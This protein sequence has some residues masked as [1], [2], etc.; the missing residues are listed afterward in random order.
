MLAML[1]VSAWMIASWPAIANAA[2]RII[3]PDAWGESASAAPEAQR[4]ASRWQAAL[5]LRLVQVVSA[6]QD[7]R[8]AE[9]VAV[10]ER[11]EPVPEQAFAT[12]TAAIEALATAVVNVV[13]TDAPADAELR[14]TRSGEQIVWAR[15]TVDD[16]RYE[17]VLAPSGDSATI[18]IAAVLASEAERARPLLD[19]LFVGLDGVSAPMPR[20]SL[21]AWQLGSIV[22]W[23]ALALGL[24]AAMLPLGDR[25][26]DHGQAGA[27]ASGI[28]LVLVLIGTGIAA[29]A[30]R[31]RELALVHAGSSV[32]GL[33]VWVGVA[34]VIVVGLHFLISS[35]LD[36]GPVQSAPSSGAFASGTYSTADVIRSS[37]SRSGMR[38]VP[39]DLEQS[40]SSGAWPTSSPSES[41]ARIVVDEAER[42]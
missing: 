31:S 39:D 20:F 6:P 15:W 4:R 36:R 7:D 35:R 11:S 27:R 18:V 9:T 24:H 42:E 17:C 38:R 33:V 8:F 41:K 10:F 32:A 34:G 21:L 2:A 14:T 30:L 40:S 12:E 5:G 3:A 29:V 16:L 25:D 1:L 28:N 26:H 13:G 19:D 22:V 23:L 37:V